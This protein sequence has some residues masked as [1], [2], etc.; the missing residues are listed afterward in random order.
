MLNDRK[1]ENQR[2]KAILQCPR[3]CLEIGWKMTFETKVLFVKG[4]KSLNLLL[5][6]FYPL[7]VH[8]NL[9]YNNFN[10]KSN[11]S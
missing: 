7:D 2:V 1:V 5:F 3:A 11:M 6:Y 4:S 10:Y 8:W 9:V